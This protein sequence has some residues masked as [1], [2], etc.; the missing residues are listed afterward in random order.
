MLVQFI[1]SQKIIKNEICTHISSWGGGGGM[2]GYST[3]TMEDSTTLPYQFTD[4]EQR[5]GVVGFN[6]YMRDR[7]T[8]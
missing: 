1:Y 4:D 6:F 7:D 3:S 8:G 5:F 2:G